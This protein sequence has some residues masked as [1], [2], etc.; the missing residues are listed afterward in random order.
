MKIKTLLL[1][2]SFTMLNISSAFSTG[3]DSD[4]L[5]MDSI[6]WDLLAKPI[7]IDSAH[8]FRFNNFLPKERSWN[9]GNWDGYTGEWEIKDGKLYLRKVI[10]KML[11]NQKYIN[12]EVQG[13]ETFFADYKTNNGILASWFSGKIRL[14]RGDVIRLGDMGFDRNYKEESVLTIED[15]VIVKKAFYHNNRKEGLSLI[16]IAKIIPERMSWKQ[17]PELDEKR[18]IAFFSHF[19]LSADGHYINSKIKVGL[20]GVYIEDE[21]HPIIIAIKEL[22]KKI[23][24]WE[25]LYINDKYR[26]AITRF[27]FPIKIMSI[28]AKEQIGINKDVIP[29]L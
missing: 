7:A 27:T 29:N 21:N 3:Q 23:Y 22:L 13:L 20:D 9:T 17:F 1:W 6:K 10:I 24:P 11:E 25:V 2:I 16:Q 4:I 12:H 14:G 26:P 5:I 8:Y 18:L 15:G 28:S 19:E